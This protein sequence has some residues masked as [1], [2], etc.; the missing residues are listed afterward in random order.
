MTQAKLLRVLQERSFER[1]GGSETIQIDVRVIAATNKDLEKEIAAGRFREDLYY[2]LNVVP[3]D[4]PPLRERRE[5]IE[6]LARRLRAGVLRASR[7]SGRASSRRSAWRR[8][9]RT[10]GR[11]TCASCAT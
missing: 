5:D 11:A 10:T 1:V 4:V 3:F 8:S 6:I 2:R 9:R 7:A